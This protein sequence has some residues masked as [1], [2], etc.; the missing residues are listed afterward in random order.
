MLKVY[1]DL[2]LSR[3]RD[4]SGEG[5]RNHTLAPPGSCQDSKI[6]SSQLG[7][8]HVLSVPSDEQAAPLG[9]KRELSSSQ[10]GPYSSYICLI[11]AQ[12]GEDDGDRARLSF[13]C[14]AACRWVG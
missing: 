11:L 6:G 12:D 4:A 1:P 13:V 14:P 10:P 2:T 5:T 9:G 7:L 8:V 3:V